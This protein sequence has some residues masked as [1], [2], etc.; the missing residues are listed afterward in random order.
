MNKLGINLWNYTNRYT[1][2]QAGLID[3]VADTGFTA[4]ELPIDDPYTVS[5]PVIKEKIKQNG[6][7]LAV[8]AVITK[9]R[10]LSCPCNEIRL[11]TMN[12]LKNCIRLTA[13]AG[14]SVLCGPIYSTGGPAVYKTSAEQRLERKLAADGIYELGRFAGNLGVTLAIEPLHR[15][16]T[17]MINTV[18]QALELCSEIGLENVGVHFDSYHANIEEDDIPGALESVLISGKLFHFHACSNSRSIPGKGHLPWEEMWSLL[19]KHNY[20][21]MINMETFSGPGI[22]AIWQSGGLSPEDAARS[23]LEYLKKYF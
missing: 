5:I 9:D 17:N 20:Q 1:D 22:E 13:E 23:G 12:Y 2:A 21:G 4:V 10:G 16:R 7:E 11:A 18:R 15:Y 3:R 8:C 14:G 6:L 19:K